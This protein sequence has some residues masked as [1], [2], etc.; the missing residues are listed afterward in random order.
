MSNL[1]I[2]ATSAARNM[3]KSNA[4]IGSSWMFPRDCHNRSG[5]NTCS[6]APEQ[7]AWWSIVHRKL[8]V[9]PHAPSGCD[10]VRPGDN[11]DLNNSPTAGA[12]MH[13]A[14]V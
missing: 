7:R 2:E 1:L 13:E 11:Y 4:S 5:K 8:L 12:K 9:V 14:K 10:V 3:R 6:R